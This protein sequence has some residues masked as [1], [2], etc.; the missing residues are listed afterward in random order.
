MVHLGWSMLWA[1][2]ACASFALEE[3][4]PVN[5]GSRRT[6]PL[7]PVSRTIFSRLCAE[8]CISSQTVDCFIVVHLEGEIKSS[9]YDR[10]KRIRFKGAQSSCFTCNHKS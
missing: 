7:F 3:L 4:Q 5:T 2:A 9:F 1:P 8:A 10:V 6:F